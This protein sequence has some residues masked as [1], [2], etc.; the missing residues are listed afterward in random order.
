ML[1]YYSSH[2]DEGV[3][4]P[5]SSVI[6]RRGSNSSDDVVCGHNKFDDVPCCL[7]ERRPSRG[8]SSPSPPNIKL[9]QHRNFKR[10][11]TLHHLERCRRR[12]AAASRNTTSCSSI[13]AEESSAPATS[14]NSVAGDIRNDVSSPVDAADVIIRRFFL[15]MDASRTLTSFTH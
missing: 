3:S 5:S 14:S 10:T 9:A 13:V 7:L 2:D 8:L 15:M 6:A 1:G 11:A 12:S 4:P